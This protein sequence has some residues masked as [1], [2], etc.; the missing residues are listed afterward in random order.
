MGVPRGAGEATE[1]ANETVICAEAQTSTTD[2][3]IKSKNRCDFIPAVPSLNPTYGKVPE[4][5]KI[6][7]EI[8]PITTFDRCASTPNKRKKAPMSATPLPLKRRNP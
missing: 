2:K 4:G 5:V 7:K 8:G 1:G 3:V 6:S